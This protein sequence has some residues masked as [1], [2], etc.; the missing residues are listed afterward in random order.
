[1]LDYNS[2]KWLLEHGEN[3]EELDI[4]GGGGRVTGKI[5]KEVAK[6]KKLRY[7]NLANICISGI[8]LMNMVNGS[9]GV[10]REVDVSGCTGIS[11]DTVR[12]A[13]KSGVKI[14]ERWRYH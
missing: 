3:L 13:A 1:M 5:S 9:S 8:G 7:L 14:V 12:L 2:L 6:F 10:L 4:S 11:L